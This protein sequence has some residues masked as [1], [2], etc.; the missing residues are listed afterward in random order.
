[1]IFWTCLVIFLISIIC[2]G[3]YLR[4]KKLEYDK[5]DDVCKECRK[6]KWWNKKMCENC[7]RKKGMDDNFLRKGL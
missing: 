2:I 1:M 3:V 5:L 6:V 7:I 4:I